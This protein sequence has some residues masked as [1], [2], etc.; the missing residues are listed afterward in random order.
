MGLASNVATNAAAT[1][2]ALHGEMLSEPI[3]MSKLDFKPPTR[4]YKCLY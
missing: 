4:D 1:E 2:A 3:Q